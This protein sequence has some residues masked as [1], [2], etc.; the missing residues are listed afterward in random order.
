MA[1]KRQP[2]RTKQ[3]APSKP[4]ASE[5]ATKAVA[6]ASKKTASKKTASGSLGAGDAASLSLPSFRLQ[7]QHGKTVS[8]SDLLGAPFVLY[9]YPKDDTPGCTQEACDFRDQSRSF[10]KLNCR[11]IGVS[12]DSGSSHARF[13]TK[14]EL[15]FTLLSDPDKVLAGA[16]GVWQLKQNYGREYMGIVRSTF[17][18][19][20][21][22]KVARAW[23]G[24][25]VKGHADS[26]LSALAELG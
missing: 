24:V 25:K 6:K 23:R 10:A 13:A 20:A 8:K 12:P 1:A 16:F 15:P 14:Y 3:P 2:P 17:L 4:G 5:K 26:V 7:D 21:R 9:F 18:I 19:D 11:V 22:G